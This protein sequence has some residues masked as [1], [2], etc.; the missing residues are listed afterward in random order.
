VSRVLCTV[1]SVLKR[2]N[3]GVMIPLG[4]Y[5]DA[6]LWQAIATWSQQVLRP[7]EFP[8]LVGLLTASLPTRLDRPALL[9][10][11]QEANHVSADSLIGPVS[12]GFTHLCQFIDQ[13]VPCAESLHKEY[14]D[15]AEVNV[16]FQTDSRA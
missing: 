3:H 16:G 10:L 7:D 6:S 13:A 5:I 8:I 1:G 12:D 14:G 15:R 9:R 11:Q 2:R 4:F